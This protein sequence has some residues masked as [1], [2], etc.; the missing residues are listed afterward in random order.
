MS[1]L[2]VTHKHEN[3]VSV[4][5]NDQLVVSVRVDR[6]GQVMVYVRDQLREVA[7]VR[8]SDVP[9]D[10]EGRNAVDALAVWLDKQNKEDEEDE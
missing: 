4:S 9:K 3:V 2:Q 5:L 8:A 6:D 7:L 1:K 10:E